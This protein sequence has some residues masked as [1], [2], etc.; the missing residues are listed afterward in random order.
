MGDRIQI[1]QHRFRKSRHICKANIPDLSVL[2]IERIENFRMKKLCER[3]LYRP[4]SD[5]FFLESFLFVADS[6]SCNKLAWE[7]AHL[8]TENPRSEV[9]L[10]NFRS[11]LP[12][13]TSELARRLVIKQ[14]LHRAL[15]CMN[16]K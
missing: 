8:R 2:N 6:T 16:M 10:A 3:S 4:G 9:L 14:T 11:R 5:C 1:L 15:G 12:V 13:Q 7:Q